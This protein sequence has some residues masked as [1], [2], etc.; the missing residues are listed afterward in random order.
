[1]NIR[2]KIESWWWSIDKW[3]LFS[4]FTLI[5][6][7]SILILSGANSIETK[8][9]YKEG[10]FF[11][12]H[13]IFVPIGISIILCSSM[14]S[15]R[16]III[17]SIIMFIVFLILSFIPLFQN[18]I[19]GASRWIKFLN[20]TIQ[21]SEFL[22]P[23]YIICSALLLSRFKKKKDNSFIINFFIISLIGLIL[24]LQPDFGMFILIFIT[25]FIQILL[26]GLSIKII[27]LILFFGLIISIISYLT[28]DHIKFRIYNFFNSDVGDNY[29]INR[30]LE[31]FS[32]GG[33]FGKGIGAGTFS[34]KLPDVHSDFIF[35]LAGE[36]LGF[37][38]L[39][40]II[41]LYIILIYR[42]V[43]LLLKEDNLFIFLSAS[44]LIITIIFQT[45]IN[46]CSTLNMI[47]TKGMTLPFLSYGG[48]SLISCSLIIGFI[49]S[50]TKKKRQI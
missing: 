13:L 46:I 48:S 15:V 41:L 31:A 8:Y 42:V 2:N 35:S 36:E 38:F 23:T 33:M 28:H 21:P 16:H 20:F 9:N 3:I 39:C 43:V 32:N 11:K 47:P 7:G 26:M 17:L 37:M 18:E 50:L 4:T 49:L 19:K 25:W 27:L 34:K 1:M 14:L 40:L 12:K 29:Q 24:F 45:L 30:S 6:I 44:S 22:K 10:Y 5:I